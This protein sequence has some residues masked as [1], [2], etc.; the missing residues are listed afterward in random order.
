MITRTEFFAATVT[1][2]G[3][4]VISPWTAASEPRWTLATDD[5]VLTLGLDQQGRLAIFELK[6]ARDGGNWTGTPS[7]FPLLDHAEVGGQSIALKWTFRNAETDNSNGTRL[8][9]RFTTD[10]P[11]LELKSQWWARPGRGPIRH[12]AFLTNHS[13]GGATSTTSN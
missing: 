13:G 1:V 7:V 6:H 11:E 5:T 4:A 12:A 3:L 2:L 9:L 10:A 8:T